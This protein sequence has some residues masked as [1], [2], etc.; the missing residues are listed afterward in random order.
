MR[1]ALRDDFALETRWVDTRSGNT[2]ESAFYTRDILL[3]RE[4]I[5]HIV[6]VTHAYHVPRATLMFERAGFAVTRAPTAFTTSP[7]RT[8]LDFLP[9]A[10]GLGMARTF[11]HETIGIGW[12]Y[13]LLKLDVE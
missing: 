9:S 8:I 6:L 1:D 2:Y 5:K 13:F 11:F 10:S 3:R 12:Y 4:N 7:P